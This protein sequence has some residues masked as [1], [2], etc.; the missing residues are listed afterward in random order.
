MIL[1]VVVSIVALPLL[2]PSLRTAPYGGSN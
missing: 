2:Q 1:V